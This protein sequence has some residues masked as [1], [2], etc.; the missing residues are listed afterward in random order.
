[1]VVLQVMNVSLA[2]GVA[3]YIDR[4]EGLEGEG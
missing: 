1:M 2:R 4:G 3:E